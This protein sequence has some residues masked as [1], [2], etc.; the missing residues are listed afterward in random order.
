MFP[1]PLSVINVFIPPN[2]EPTF[3]PEIV[4]HNSLPALSRPTCIPIPFPSPERTALQEAVQKLPL[5]P[6][7]DHQLDRVGSGSLPVAFVLRGALSTDAAAAG[8]LGGR[9]RMCA[10]SELL[11]ALD[12]AHMVSFDPQKEGPLFP[13]GVLPALC[14]AVVAVSA[15]KPLWVQTRWRG[16]RDGVAVRPGDIFLVAPGAL[17]SCEFF[18]AGDP[19]AED[20]TADMAVG[21]WRD[22][23][24]A[25]A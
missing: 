1:D 12:E 9:L 16:N 3:V 14:G 2:A 11:V 21:L 18:R 5:R 10:S 24:Q 22:T 4:N 20:I 13:D 25:Q 19:W 7:T 17:R 15:P 8:T 23:K 6:A